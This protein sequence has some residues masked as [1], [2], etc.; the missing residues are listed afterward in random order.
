MTG[1]IGFLQMIKMAERANRKVTGNG[2]KWK[3]NL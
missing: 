1:K 2:K 3:K